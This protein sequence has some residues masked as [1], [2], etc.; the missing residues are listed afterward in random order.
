[1]PRP[2]I[3]LRT[4]LAWLVLATTVPLAL[5]AGRL[6]WTSWTQQQ[7]LVDRQNVEQARSVSLSVDLE[8][9]RAMT[10]LEVLATLEPIDYEDRTH[11]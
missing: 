7:A 6:I 4:I 5:F 11:S 2:R 8:I 3:H 1:M 9:N 10:A